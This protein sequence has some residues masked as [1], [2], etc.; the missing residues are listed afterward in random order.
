MTDNNVNYDSKVVAV[1]STETLVLSAATRRGAVLLYNQGAEDIQFYF[2]DKSTAYF[3][4]AAGTGLE[5]PDAPLN[6][7]N[8][9]T[10]SGTSN[11]TVMWS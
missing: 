3:G 4:I 9:V 6:E 5:I 2:G 11:L 8:A 1:T 10:A 7:I